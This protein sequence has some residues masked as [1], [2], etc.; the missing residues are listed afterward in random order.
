MAYDDRPRAAVPALRAGANELGAHAL[1]DL[2][3]ESTGRLTDVFS[4]FGALRHD[5]F[6][7]LELSG[8]LCLLLRRG[9]DGQ[10]VKRTL[11]RCGARFIFF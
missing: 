6:D 4:A 10:R 11:E 2:P 5:S 8:V 7:G 3:R 1:R 9:A